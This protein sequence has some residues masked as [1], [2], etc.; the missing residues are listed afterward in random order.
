MNGLDDSG[1]DLL[2]RLEDLGR[3]ERERARQAGHQ[4]ATLDLH[5]LLLGARI[6]AADGLF[7]LLRRALADERVVLAAHIFDDRLVELVARDLDRGGLDDA[8]ERDDRDVGR[9]AADVSDQ[10]AVRPADV[11]TRADGR[12][13]RLFDEVHPA[14][15]EPS[16]VE[17]NK[18]TGKLVA[19]GRNTRFAPACVPASMTAR[20]S[21]SVM[22]EG[23]QMTT[24]GLN[25]RKPCTLRMN[26]LIISSVIS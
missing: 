3:A 5:D 25:R 22:I 14:L 8:A 20:S 18:V 23:T 19:V 15:N 10:I 12:R 17:V 13:H 24:F 1:G 16:V 7:D 21:T 4:T 2:E 26:S 11:E 9:A 6:D